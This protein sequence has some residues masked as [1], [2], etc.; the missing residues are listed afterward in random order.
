MPAS[1][2]LRLPDAGY[3][4]IG[5]VGP[6]AWPTS[7]DVGGDLGALGGLAPAGAPAA[8]AGPSGVEIEAA[9]HGGAAVALEPG[10]RLVLVRLEEGHGVPAGAP[11]AVVDLSLVVA[12]RLVSRPGRAQ[13]GPRHA[14][15]HDV[16]LPL[17]SVARRRAGQ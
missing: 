8:H 17:E 2:G 1:T 10:D 12:A 15:G 6:V 11:H 9:E 3:R 7:L 14:G 13:R 4:T 16:P 5:K